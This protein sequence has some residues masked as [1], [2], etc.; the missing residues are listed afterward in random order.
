MAKKVIGRFIVNGV[1]EELKGENSY[2]DVELFNDVFKRTTDAKKKYTLEDGARIVEVPY[3]DSATGKKS[4]VFLYYKEG[5]RV[6][7]DITNYRMHKGEMIL[8]LASSS[9]DKADVSVRRKGKEYRRLHRRLW[10]SKKDGVL[11]TTAGALIL[12]MLTAGTVLG[13]VGGK[14]IA[15][16]DAKINSDADTMEKQQHDL[17]VEKEINEH[18]Q[19]EQAFAHGQKEAKEKSNY[20]VVT[21]DGVTK[22]EGAFKLA[23]IEVYTHSVQTPGLTF[24]AEDYKKAEDKYNYE[25]Y[26][27][28]GAFDSLGTS[29]AEKMI[30]NGMTIAIINDQGTTYKTELLDEVVSGYKTAL[31]SYY[32]DC[33]DYST[34]AFKARVNEEAKEAESE[35]IE[36]G[37]IDTQSDEVLDAAAN[38]IGEEVGAVKLNG[39]GN[40][41][42]IINA[43]DTHMFEFELATTPITTAEFVEALA[44]E[45]TKKV[46]DYAKAK[47]VVGKSSVFNDMWVASKFDGDRVEAKPEMVNS[48]TGRAI[49]A[50]DEG[51][52]VN[53]Y[54][55]DYIKYKG[56]AYSTPKSITKYS[57]LSAEGINFAIPED[58]EILGSELPE[59]TKVSSNSGRSL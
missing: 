52:I 4:C 5:D 1:E 25:G 32:K 31:G 45:D 30:E 38:K 17:A 8:E 26:T 24:T 46:E 37:E 14:A 53:G 40:R 16:K 49:Y 29:V 34:E 15:T 48:T 54:N 51:E 35:A 55:G 47:D 58:Y 10:V 42:F 7:K 19:R 3:I 20:Q 18:N 36:Q 33:A 22:V 57:I 21:R 9:G 50:K 39:E 11:K 2:Y 6:A 23:D 43:T 56:S 12:V 27:Y 44:S 41:V 59:G 28:Y 13:F